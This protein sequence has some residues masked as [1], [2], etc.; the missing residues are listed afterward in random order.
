MRIYL[1]SRD[2]DRKFWLNFKIRKLLIDNHYKTIFGS[3]RMV[4][5]SYTVKT[6]HAWQFIEFVIAWGGGMEIS[7]VYQG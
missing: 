7:E 3:V 1:F 6:G 5:S 4:C 2:L